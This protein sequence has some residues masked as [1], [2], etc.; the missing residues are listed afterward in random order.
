MAQNTS[1]HYSLQITGVSSN[2]LVAKFDARESISGLFT[3]EV[4]FSS[5]DKEIALPDVVGKVAGLSLALEDEEPRW[6][7]GIVSRIRHMEGGKKFA[8]YQMTIVPKLWK[9]THRHDSRIF[10]S[11]SVPEI[12]EAV[13]GTAGLSDYRLSLTGS[14]SP[15]DYCVQYR[16]SDFAFISRLMEEE[17]IFYFFEHAEDKHTLV[18]GDGKGAI[19]PIAAPDTLPYKLTHGAA[20]M[21]ENV[22][23]F[24]SSAEV[25]PGKV[26]LTDYNFTKPTLS[27]QASSS[28]D[29]D[30]DL[31]VY[32]YP[33]EYELPADGTGYS[34][35]R[36]EEFQVRRTVA[37]GESSCMR[38][39]PGFTFT[40]TDH[41]RA[42]ENAT[43]LLTE[44][45][46]RG[47][48]PHVME[49]VEGEGFT[50]ANSF[51][52]IPS[53]TPYR[54]ERKTPRPTIKG[55]QT[56]IVTGPGGQEIHTDEHGRVKVHF[57]WDRL[58]SKDDK[59]SCWI[60]VSQL[61]AGGG[62]GAMWIPRI[63]HEVVVDF[64]EGDPDRPLITGRVYHGANVPPYA[65]PGEKT[66]S[67]IKSNSSPGGGG[68]NELRFEDKAGSEE[69]YLHGQKDWNIKIEHDKNQLIGHDETKEVG[70]DETKLVKHDESYEIGNDQKL[71]VDR[72]RKKQVKRD[73]QEK[74]GNDKTIEV[75]HDHKE[76]I[77]RNQSVIVGNNSAL[78]VTK[79]LAESVGGKHS[80]DVGSDSTISIGG[81]MNLSTGKDLAESVGGGRSESIGKALSTN[82]SQGVTL[83]IGKDYSIDVTKNLKQD[84]K[85]EMTTIV[86]KKVA[87]QCG[88]A[89][90]TVE[91]S[92]DITIHG[93]KIVLEGD[94]P[95]QVKGKKLDVKSDG[96]INIEASGKVVIKGSTVGVN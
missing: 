22:A 94:G 88:Q 9:L 69:I 5:D 93:K 71:I 61:W 91:K 68:S 74:V 27:L 43:H 16:E 56:A 36:L 32:D 53:D 60:R 17:G 90:I 48:Q 76:Q 52:T 42:A 25:R 55:I 80:L 47:A 81:A 1:I 72:D 21:G 92:G 2:L 6:F 12:I 8:F 75:G 38:F 23:N 96:A 24:S 70:H 58:G 33:G 44:V 49:S 89:T 82:V 46:H 95:I 29:L 26:T 28:G 13:L 57:H 39:M 50:Y 73:Q 51:H 41:P 19:A 83:K 79:D 45:H 85:E 34:K 35:V 54:P 77:G 67:T 14:Y 66:K 7:N 86:G 18:I 37:S 64:V 11:K 87:I 84:V 20:S 30:T 10:Q 3:I 59:S 78:A 40:L 63:G 62:W 65:L 31:E 15:R 4:T